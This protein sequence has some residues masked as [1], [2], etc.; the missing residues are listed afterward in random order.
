MNKAFTRETDAAEDDQ[1]DV[2]SP[3][4]S[5]ARNYMTPGGFGRMKSELDRLVQKE[6]PELVATVAWAAGNGDRSENGDYIYGKKRLRE[7]DRRIRFL[8]RRLD[9]AEVVDPAARRDEGSD[10]V[11]FGATVTVR[12]ATGGE[13]TVSIV[14]VD[15]IDTDRGYVSW[16]S[17]IARALIKARE[18]DTVSLHTPRGVEELEIVSVRYVPLATDDAAAAAALG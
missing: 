5:G 3:L 11:F 14:G 2:A 7:I 12:D 15:E 8:V 1:Q 4:P 13:R 17:P 10:Q 6:R 16:V 9:V 18:G